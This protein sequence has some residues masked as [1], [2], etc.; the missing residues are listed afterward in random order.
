MKILKLNILLGLLAVSMLGFATNYTSTQTGNWEDGTTWVNGVVPDTRNNTITIV[1]GTTVTGTDLYFDKITTIIIQNNAELIINISNVST[2]EKEFTLNVNDGGTLTINGDFTTGDDAILTID[3]TLTIHGDFITDDDTE[4]TID[5]DVT[6]NGNLTL[7]DEIVITVDLDGTSGG[8]LNITG[9]LTSEGGVLIGL[10]LVHVWGQATGIDDLY[11]GTTQLPIELIYFNA[12]NNK[13]NITLN[14]QTATEDNNDY[15][16]LERSADGVNYEIIG[17]V[18]GA[19][20][21]SVT[22]NY[23]YTDNNP[24]NGVSYYRLTQTDYNGD[25]EVFSPVSVSFLNEGNLEVYPN[26][27]INEFNISMA[28]S[29]G[30]VSINLYSVIGTLVKNNETDNNF[31]TIDISDLPSGYYMMVISANNSKITKKVVIQ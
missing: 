24:V 5:G 30:R 28:G 27:A 25:F 7:G 12:N 21:S 29:M 23:S 20:N 15:F 22:L 9:N 18:L 10:G 4:L 1:T 11:D 6:I 31:T 3:G 26:P 13:T 17:T 8:V 16:T 2:A 19:G 14:W